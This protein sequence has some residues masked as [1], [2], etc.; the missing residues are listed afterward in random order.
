MP[1]VINKIRELYP[2]IQAQLEQP[3]TAVAQ[4]AAYYA[5]L[6]TQG[7]RDSD[8]DIGEEPVNPGEKKQPAG[9]T[10]F[11]DDLTP[12]SFGMGVNSR[13]QGWIVNN[14]VKKDTVIGE[15]THV[16]KTYYVPFDG[17]EQV[18]VP[19]YQNI[20]QSDFVKPCTDVN[21]EPL[22]SDPQDQVSELG[23]FV[24]NIPEA[25]RKKGHPM[26][27]D[28]LVDS[29]GVHIRVTDGVSGEEFPACDIVYNNSDF[30]KEEA[31]EK[32]EA[33]EIAD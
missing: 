17:C 16:Q 24:L 27:V 1:M 22:E 13:T 28:F 30:N 12:R 15:L 26:N 5:S 20:S 18:N 8:E 31:E 19:V 23:K 9:F 6:I 32:I 2:D 33:F 29:A 7:Y 25:S 11:V 3:D 10:D 4:G 14:L 21:G